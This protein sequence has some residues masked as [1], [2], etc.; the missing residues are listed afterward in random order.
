MHTLTKV[1]I[2]IVGL[3][4]V[5]FFAGFA[6][7]ARQGAF[8]QVRPAYYGVYYG[9]TYRAAPCAPFGAWGCFRPAPA[10]FYGGGRFVAHRP[11]FRRLGGRPG[12]RR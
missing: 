4:A 12:F 5:I 11:L 2:G 10:Y 3:C 7:P 1:L 9:P 8:H 6:F